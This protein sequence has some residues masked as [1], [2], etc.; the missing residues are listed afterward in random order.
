MDD[1]RINLAIFNQFWR[2]RRFSTVVP[3]Q[4]F[5]FY[6]ENIVNHLS[7][8]EKPVTVVKYNLISCCFPKKGSFILRFSSIFFGTKFGQKYVYRFLNILLICLNSFS[9]SRNCLPLFEVQW[10][11]AIFIMNLPNGTYPPSSVHGQ[12]KLLFSV[13]PWGCMNLHVTSL[14]STFTLSMSTT[15]Q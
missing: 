11:A 2:F 13:G 4:Y 9:L 10:G 6:S 12:W 1:E 5:I 14:S 7:E 8:H 3:T 15:H